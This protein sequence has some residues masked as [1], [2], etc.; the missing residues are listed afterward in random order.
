MEEERQRPPVVDPGPEQGV[1]QGLGELGQLRE[2]RVAG[3]VIAPITSSDPKIG[4]IFTLKGFLALAIGGFGSIR[5]AIV[6]GIG[7]GICEQ[8]WDLKY[9]GHVGSNYEILVGL[10]L[11]LTVLLLRPQG[12]FSNRNARTV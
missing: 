12:L 9:P 11:V 3:V 4:L 7:L 8:L 6:G 1:V 2:V 10:I 5:G